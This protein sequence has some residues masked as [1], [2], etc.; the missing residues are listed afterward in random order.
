MIHG[1]SYIEGARFTEHYFPCGDMREYA[2]LKK[3]IV[4]DYGIINLINHGF[5]LYAETEVGLT[6]MINNL[7][8]IEREVGFEKLK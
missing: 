6:H 1:H 3:N 2:E 7:K 5:F 8:F 4:G